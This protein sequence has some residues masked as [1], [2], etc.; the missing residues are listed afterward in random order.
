MTIIVFRSV[1]IY[2]LVVVAVRIMGKRQLGELN[3]HEFVITI[4]I[5]AVATI[6]IQESSI[7]LSYSALPILIFVSFE[8]LESA[9]SM[10][11]EKFRKIIDG[12]PIA[13]IKNGK[14]Q[15]QELRRLRF[16]VEDLN[17]A[18]RQKDVFDI[19][20][21]ENAVVETNGSLSVEKKEE[22]KN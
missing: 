13:I 6:P 8:I 2:L 17:E 19:N 12:K 15:Q 14:L 7:P 4:L 9:I 22:D 3:P 21:V 20:E 18:L 10:K 16:T 1:I 11:S 5:S